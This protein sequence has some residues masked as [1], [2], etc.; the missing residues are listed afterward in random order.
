MRTS[1]IM[2]QQIITDFKNGIADEFDVAVAK[3]E[4]IS[5]IIEE[6]RAVMEVA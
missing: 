5:K 1:E 3:F 6:D 4:I 2:K